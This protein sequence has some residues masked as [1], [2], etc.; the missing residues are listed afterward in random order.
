MNKNMRAVNAMHHKLMHLQTFM[1][2]TAAAQAHL[3][4]NNHFANLHD[5]LTF[6]KNP[7]LAALGTALEKDA[8]QENL[9]VDPSLMHLQDRLKNS[10]LLRTGLIKGTYKTAYETIKSNQQEFAQAYAAL[11]ELD[12]LH[13][14]ASLHVDYPLRYNVPVFVDLKDPWIQADEIW[15]PMLDPETAVTNSLEFDGV[16]PDN[17]RTIIVSGPNGHGKTANSTVGQPQAY[18]L[19]N[20]GIAPASTYVSTVFPIVH[21]L[22]KTESKTGEGLSLFMSIAD[23]IG[24]TLEV[25]NEPGFKFITLDEPG[26]GTKITIG[27]SIS[28]V[29]SRSIALRPD[30]LCITTTHYKSSTLLEQEHPRFIAN[31][32]A[33]PG[34]KLERGIGSFENEKSGVQVLEQYANKEFAD[35][36]EK[37]MMQAAENEK[38]S[39][40]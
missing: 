20:Q 18:L 1:R 28:R 12:Y 34:Y 31:Y 25:L 10:G 33:V 4:G 3:A 2:A 22:I 38:T 39:K 32:R 30:T 7:A 37:D 17:P 6:K 13:A 8:F 36:V 19:A 15:S 23:R 16:C 11:G 9:P 14:L 5:R 21:T 24:K 26:N 40:S 29:L 27:N 35:E